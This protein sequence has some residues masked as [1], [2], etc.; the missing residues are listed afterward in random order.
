MK[1]TSM[2]G[3]SGFGRILNLTISKNN[4]KLFSL[5]PPVQAGKAH[6]DFCR[7]ERLRELLIL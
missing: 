5:S 6:P 3:K 2:I 4:P 1:P 7:R